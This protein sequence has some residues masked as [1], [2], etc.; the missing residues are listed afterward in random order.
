MNKQTIGYWVTTALV[1]FVF[2]AGGVF[3]LIRP[4]QLVETMQHLGYATYVAVIL[5]AWKVAGAVVI[6][7]PRLPLLKEWAYAGMVFDLTGAALSHR[8]VGDPASAV[9]TPIIILSLVAASWFLRPASR[10]LSE[11]ATLSLAGN[12]RANQTVHA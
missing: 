8:A 2:L 12:R 1:V 6:V 3:D 7:A 10:R 4:P 11:T 9:A 5:G